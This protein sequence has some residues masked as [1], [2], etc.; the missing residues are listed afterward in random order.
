MKNQNQKIQFYIGK[1]GVGKSTV[2]ALQALSTAKKG[3]QTLLI[4]LDPAHNQQ[5][6]FETELS[7]KP[8]KVAEN[9][10][11][12]EPNIEHW[13]KKYLK[14]SEEKLQANYSYQQAF[15]LKNYFKLFRYSPAVEEYAML[16]AMEHYVTN[17]PDKLIIVDMPPTALSLRFFALPGISIK[18]LEQLLELRI[19]INKKKE[20]I[21]QLKI[22]TKELETDKVISQLK[23][24]MSTYQKFQAL[25]SAELTEINLVANPEK[26]SLNEAKRI[27]HKIN[28]IGLNISCLVLNKVIV[29]NDFVV[30]NNVLNHLALIQFN[31]SDETLL[32][33]DSLNAFLNSTENLTH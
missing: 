13:I 10:L 25:F 8:V 27:Y 5:D 3:A 12:A 7:D 23:K 32:G 6:I 33:L 17:F 26:L 9:L 14:E 22:G 28:D 30:E 2:S 19:A 11:I 29:K 1:G 16:M 4:S 24:I 20:I 31:Y 18:W 21:S 15:S